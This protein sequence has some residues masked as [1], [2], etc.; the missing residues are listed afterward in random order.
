MEEVEVGGKQV[1][2]RPGLR[3]NVTEARCFGE[4]FRDPEKKILSFGEIY[5]K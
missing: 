1:R 5:W 3:R 4:N 2:K